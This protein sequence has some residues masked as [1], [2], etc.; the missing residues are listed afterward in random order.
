ML[1]DAFV[2]FVRTT[3]SNVKQIFQIFSLISSWN[4]DLRTIETL[5]TVLYNSGS[6][7]IGLEI[8]DSKLRFLV[9]KGSN[10]VELISDRNVSDGRWHSV[11]IAYSPFVVEVS[12]HRKRES[13][14]DTH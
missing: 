10:A 11:S 12:V 2:V 6:D 1:A 5:G 3:K 7:S 8:V 14:P 13:K 9:S 4:M